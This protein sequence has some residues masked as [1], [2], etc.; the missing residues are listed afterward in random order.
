MDRSNLVEIKKG[1][2]TKKITSEEFINRSILIHNN[3]FDYSKVEY[4]STKKK[5]III[6][7]IHGEFEQSPETHLKSKCGCPKCVKSGVIYIILNIQQL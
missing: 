5:V 6:C 7:P 2:S 4:Q 3:K 1:H